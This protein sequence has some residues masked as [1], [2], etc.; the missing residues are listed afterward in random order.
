TIIWSNTAPT[1]DG[2]EIYV[3]NATA[4]LNYCDYRNNVNDIVGLI[5]ANNCMTSD[6]LFIN[7]SEDNYCLQMTS[8][9]IDSGCDEYVYTGISSLYCVIDMNQIRILDGNVDAVAI[10]DIGAY[11]Y[12]YPY[13]ITDQYMRAQIDS[14]LWEFVTIEVLWTPAPYQA[15]A[16]E[17]CISVSDFTAGTLILSYIDINGNDVEVQRNIE[18]NNVT[19]HMFY[20]EVAVNRLVDIFGPILSPSIN[21]LVVVSMNFNNFITI[22][23]KPIKLFDHRD[24]QS[25]RVTDKNEPVY[26][27]DDC[28]D[29]KNDDLS[30]EESDEELEKRGYTRGEQVGENIVVQVNG[31]GDSYNCHGWAFTC[32]KLVIPNMLQ[33]HDE[34]PE[35]PVE[36]VLTHNNYKECNTDRLPKNGD[37][38]VYRKDGKITHTEIIT[39]VDENTGE[40]TEVES[41]WG[42]MGRYKHRP[43][44]VPKEDSQNRW[45]AFG[46]P[47]YYYTDRKPDRTGKEK[48]TLDEPKE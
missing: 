37:L 47:K 12:K 38:V 35:Y 48:N 39:K 11:E 23:M 3:H 17:S 8:L 31:P 7:S 42:R 36:K 43:E 21:D 2:N 4:T 34:P 15:D 32:G 13:A 5:I 26:T 28:T 22:Q 27:K 29:S 41:K 18:I 30:Q 24:E 1:G 44:D 25:K 46:Q 9:C 10:V 45:G 20:N 40:V 19:Q 14:S 6:P 33:K 16:S